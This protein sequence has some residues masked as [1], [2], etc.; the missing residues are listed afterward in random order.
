MFP[1]LRKRM[2]VYVPFAHF[3][4]TLCGPMDCS[5]PGSSVHGDSPGKN[6]GVG[7]HSLFQGIFP[8]QESNPALPHWRQILYHRVTREARQEQS[9][10]R[11]LFFPPVPSP[12]Y[13]TGDNFSE[14][15]RTVAH[16]W[17]W[18]AIFFSQ[19]CPSDSP[20]FPLKGCSFSHKGALGTSHEP[21][22]VPVYPLPLE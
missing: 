2:Q 11:V 4:L 20:S 6:A 14:E 5:P 17:V 22:K 21:W 13:F 3:C 9:L 15:P 7:C 8:T 16:G 10:S 1:L 19:K 12:C 18:C